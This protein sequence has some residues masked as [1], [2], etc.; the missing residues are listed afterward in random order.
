METLQEY[1]DEIVQVLIM[2]KEAEL[3]HETCK[4]DE[5]IAFM[6][7]LSVLGPDKQ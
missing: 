3:V 4:I 1:I 7:A 5:C 2:A 6:K